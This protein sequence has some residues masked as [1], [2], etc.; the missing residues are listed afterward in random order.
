MARQARPGRNVRYGKCVTEGCENYRQT[1]AIT[2]GDFK[3]PKCEKELMECPPPVQK[4]APVKMIAIGAVAVIALAGG[5]F[6]LFGGKSDKKAT[7]PRTEQVE[8]TQPN[9]AE[10]TSKAAEAQKAAEEAEKA[11]EAQKA[12]AEA[13]KAEEAQKAAEEA[14]KKGET[15]AS[16]TPTA[17]PR[18]ASYGTVKLSYGTY[19]GDL[20][21]GQPHGHGKL[22]YTKSHKIVASQSYV[23]SP[24]DTYEGDFRNG[25]VSGAPGYWKHDGE[26]NL[27]KP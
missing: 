27:V 6:A 17:A 8:T 1:V 25:V 4:K 2:H 12:A 26:M 19:T 9:E 21:N 7:K 24:G 11:E 3:C 15:S 16:A 14:K 10:E 22:T 23:A 13:M 18:N 20:K 5:G